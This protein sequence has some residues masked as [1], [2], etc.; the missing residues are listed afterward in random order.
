M[1]T[2]SYT[3][4]AVLAAGFA[5]TGDAQ[6]KP[7]SKK[8]TELKFSGRI[9]GQWDGIESEEVGG[10][11]RNHFY[12]RRLFLG[13]HAKVG[14]N[15]GGDIV[16]D[17]AASTN[18][19]DTVFIDGASVW[20]NH[21]DALRIDV[22]QLKVPF[23]VEETTSSSK[24]K[25]IERSAV[26][27]QF[28]EQL[29]F[30]ARH[31]GIFAKGKFSDFL[32]YDL[33]VVNSGQNHTSK[34]SDL[35]DGEYGSNR[36][37][38]GYYGRLTY[39][40]Y[41]SEL[42]HYFGA[43]TGVMKVG[44][45]GGDAA[46]RNIA[47]DITA[48]NIFAGFGSG[49]F[50]LDAEYMFGDVSGVDHEHDGYSVQASYAIS[51]APAGSWELV[52]RYSSVENSNGEVGA[53]EIVRRANFDNNDWDNVAKLEQNYIGVN[54]LFNGHDA[55]FMLGYEMNKITDNVAANGSANADGFRARIQFLF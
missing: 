10:E 38:L 23:G 34:D 31:T 43:A 27:R 42:R 20:Y 32:S 16:M 35:K 7:K 53:D 22:G 30:N 3:L 4:C 54:Y 51:N 26:N 44:Q 21:S 11:N 55:K 24:L 14:D 37:E 1:K 13:G 45:D 25:A 15:W 47:E 33:A 39:A 2:L 46:Y 50:N 17:F 41:E 52:Y 48:Y 19:D 8:V 5:F 29:K 6:V 28:A 49:P 12:F 40:N 36:N 18:N 9:Q